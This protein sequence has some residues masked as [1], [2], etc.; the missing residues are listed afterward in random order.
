MKYRA[1]RVCAV[2]LALASPLAGR[3]SAAESIPPL[4]ESISLNP[5]GT[6]FVLQPSGR[7][8]IPRGFNYDH[9]RE[10]RLL[11]DYWDAEWSS[12]VEDWGKP[13]AELKRGQTI[14]D[15]LML[16][17]LECFQTNAPR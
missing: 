6:A 15:A 4:Q 12:V 9:D 10:G 8:F 3:M 2:I 13:P 17:W 5:G 1:T 14:S 11:E 16:Q 7:P